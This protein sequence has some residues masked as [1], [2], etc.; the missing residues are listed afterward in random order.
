MN[1]KL[2]RTFILVLG[3]I[4]ISLGMFSCSKEKIQ[5]DKIIVNAK[6]YTSNLDNMYATCC[7]IKDGKFV[8]VGD[9]KGIDKYQGEKV[10]MN[11]KFIMPSIID[12]HVHVPFSVALDYNPLALYIL[13]NG[14]D[15]CLEFIKNSIL[16][17][18]GQEMYYFALSH[19]MLNGEKLTKDDLDKV[20][21]DS[22]VIVIEAEGH[23]VWANTKVLTEHG[24]NN[25]TPDMVPGLS[26]YER[27][28]DGNI[29]GYMVEM[30]AADFLV[31]HADNITDEQIIASLNKFFDF[32]KQYGVSTVFDAG[33]PGADKFHER[34]YKILCDLDNEGKLPIT[35]E[36]CYIAYSPK[37]LEDAITNLKRYRETYNTKH[38]KV[39]TLKVI[40]DG[41]I[42]INTAALIEPYAD[43]PDEYGGSLYD[44][45]D[46]VSLLKELNKENF[47]FHSHT[48]GERA[49]KQVLDA[50]EDVKKEIGDE[51]KINVTCAHIEIARE[52]DLKRFGELGVMADFSAW[53]N[54]G[55]CGADALIE[56]QEK[57]G[58]ERA[59]NKLRSKTVLESGALVG[60]SS[61][62]ITFGDFT[63]WNPYLGI[64]LGITRNP[65]SN[66]R[67]P[68]NEI[69]NRVYPPIDECMTLNEMLFGYTSNNAKILNL[70]N[71]GSIEVGMDADYLVFDKDLT[72]I[73]I[74]GFSY[75]EPIEVY[76]EGIKMK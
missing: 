33:S 55:G 38:V 34:V 18:P 2:I 67:L 57:L 24:I 15:E 5:V 68:E 20:S 61:D 47:N 13:G 1:K 22:K 9:D 52:E 44:D 41:T 53:W 14:K 48:V 4:M 40:A 3:L 35:F 27:D 19:M 62:N 50:V 58:E 26:T 60:F 23:S 63:T 32:C 51:F 42:G 74:E 59:N 21:N 65:S 29:T 8:Y 37:Q 43:K 25:D 30:T 56:M 16:E 66:T 49:V 46:L 17:N 72:N 71:K 10:D 12:G 28:E 39:N 75:I 36:G 69:F 73:E 7:A 64:E 6:I 54:G 70:P 11:G 31:G 76:F 45:Y